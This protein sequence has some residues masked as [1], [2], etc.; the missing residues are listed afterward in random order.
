MR[1][2]YPD[3]C[4]ETRS[5][6]LM[7]ERSMIAI[8][9]KCW[10]WNRKVSRMFGILTSHDSWNVA[11]SLPT[12]ASVVQQV[13]VPA[14]VGRLLESYH[15]SKLKRAIKAPKLFFTDTGLCCFL[16][17]WSDF[18]ALEYCAFY[19]LWTIIILWIRIP[20][21]FPC[22]GLGFGERVFVGN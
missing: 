8:S 16:A 5:L 13:P 1:Q 4:V 22:H 11:L 18:N 3:S 17:G 12:I 19:L 9:I 15:N 10:S 7:M 6:F 2:P 21:L 14:V 20:R